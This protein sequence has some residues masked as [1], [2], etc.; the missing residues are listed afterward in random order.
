MQLEISLFRWNPRVGTRAAPC[1]PPPT[2]PRASQSESFGGSNPILTGRPSSSSGS[3]WVITPT[4]CLQGS[5]SSAIGSHVVR[6]RC[7]CSSRTPLSGGG[8]GGGGHH[9]S[10]TINIP[11]KFRTRAFVPSSP[12]L[13]P[14]GLG[15]VAAAAAAT[16]HCHATQSCEWMAAAAWTGG[17]ARGREGGREDGGAIFHTRSPHS[18]SLPRSEHRMGS[19]KDSFCNKGR[20]SA[21]RGADCR[22]VKGHPPHCSAR[23]PGDQIS[24]PR[25]RMHL[26]CRNCDFWSGLVGHGGGGVHTHGQETD[27]ETHEAADSPAPSS[28]SSSSSSCRSRLAL[29]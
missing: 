11:T 29:N 1:F 24:F 25:N 12:S 22:G 7:V 26:F 23:G 8:G 5:S 19:L 2:V 4:F 14:C 21:C 18:G 28:S 10:I 6:P 17:E 15:A 20:I 13:P 16:P 27:D 3:P 9:Y